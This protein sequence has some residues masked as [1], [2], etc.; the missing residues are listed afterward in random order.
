MPYYFISQFLWL[1]SV[2]AR[3]RYK[4]SHVTSEVDETISSPFKK[5]PSLTLEGHQFMWNPSGWKGSP[6]IRQWTRRRDIQQAL[7]YTQ[8]AILVHDLTDKMHR[9]YTNDRPFELNSVVTNT[10]FNTESSLNN[11]SCPY[12]TW[13]ELYGQRSEHPQDARPHLCPDSHIT[14]NCI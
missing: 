6:V 2:M 11:C 12:H 1:W 10:A 4:Y 9:I 14:N 3:L 5:Q 7:F 13:M 8:L